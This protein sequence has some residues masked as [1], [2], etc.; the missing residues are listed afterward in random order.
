M[1]Q[2]TLKSHRFRAEREADWRRLE[3]LLDR[4][5]KSRGS[6]LSDDEV[7]A[8]PVLYRSALSS[9]STARAVSLDQNLIAYLE[10]LCTRAYYCVYGTRSTVAERIVRF[11]VRDWPLSVQELWR[12]TI[13]SGALGLLATFTAYFLV[14]A[15]SAWFYDFIPGGLAEGRDPGA[16]TAALRETLFK[17]YGADGLGAFSSFLFTHNAQISLLAF[18]LGFAA[19]LPTA[20]LIFDNGLMLGAFFAVYAAHGLGFDLGGWLFIHGVTELFAV[21]LAG[22]A[23]FRIGWAL[24]FPGA[25]SRI[26]AIKDAGRVAANVMVGVVIMLMFAGLLEGF[27]RQ[28]ITN[29]FAR[30][31]VAIATGIVWFGY[32]YVYRPGRQA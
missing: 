15:N 28:L 20:F 12:E 7:V 14:R 30:Y 26:D 22:A 13:V 19:C 16:S 17:S 21:T 29:T 23:G 1:E 4:F 24:A 31:G 2:L 27:G 10:S 3:D 6:S 8:I 9:L 5:E 11:L 18:A 32:F 25:Q